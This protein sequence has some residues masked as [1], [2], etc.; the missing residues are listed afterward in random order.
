MHI[1]GAGTVV[2][3][4]K[5]AG[6]VNYMAAADVQQTLIINRAAQTITFPE[7]PVAVFG[8]PDINPGAVSSSGLA[9]T[10]SSSNT[11]VAVIT[12]GLIQIT[13]AGSA[14]ITASQPGDDDYEPAPAVTRSIVVT[15][16]DQTVTF[17]ALEPVTYGDPVITPEATASSGL[18]LVYSSSDPSVASVSGSSYYYQLR[19]YS[20]NHSQPAGK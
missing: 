12:G 7:L 20:H 15:R 16:A 11:S 2:I 18:P 14:V 1:T 4:A 3:T 19:R 6:D 13:G 5:Q 10:F 9:V 8:D 17:P